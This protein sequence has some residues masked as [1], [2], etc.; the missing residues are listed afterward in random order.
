MRVEAGFQAEKD[1]DQRLH[2]L[3]ETEVLSN[4]RAFPEEQL[5]DK[6]TGF[7]FVFGSAVE[8]SPSMISVPPAVAICSESINSELL[9]EPIEKIPRIDSFKGLPPLQLP[10][11]IIVLSGSRDS[12]SRILVSPRQHRPEEGQ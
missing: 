3:K 9:A 12:I 10:P 6:E 8:Q 11:P 7:R 4:R 5:Y 1:E 2:A